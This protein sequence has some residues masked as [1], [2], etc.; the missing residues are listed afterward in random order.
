MQ[1]EPVVALLLCSCREDARVHPGEV[2]APAPEKGSG[3]APW[4]LPPLLC[5][6]TKGPGLAGARLQLSWGS[7]QGPACC[8]WQI[9]L[10]HCTQV[11][12][13]LKEP[14]LPL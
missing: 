3:S 9:C 1:E 4:A 7:M 11:S 14:H 8:R 12:F 5:L 10:P 6:V 13:D 2:G